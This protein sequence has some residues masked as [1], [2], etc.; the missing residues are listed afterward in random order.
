[1]VWLLWVDFLGEFTVLCSATCMLQLIFIWF[2]FCVRTLI[3]HSFLTCVF[4]PPASIHNTSVTHFGPEAVCA[5][6]L[7]LAFWN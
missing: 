6:S 4:G 5:Y 1:M 7:G 2:H 3:S